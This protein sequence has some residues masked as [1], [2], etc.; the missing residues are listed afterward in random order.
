MRKVMMAAAAATTVLLASGLVGARA[1]DMSLPPLY[2]SEPEP[3]VEFG[4]GWYLRGDLGYSSISAPMGSPPVE[5]ITSA[6]TTYAPSSA[7]SVSND[8]KARYGAINATLGAGYQF[9]RWFRMDATFDWHQNHTITAKTYGANCAKINSLDDIVYQNPVCNV[10]D[11]LHVETWTGLVNAYGDLGTWFGVTPYF[12]G[13]IGLTNIRATANENY[14]KNDGTAYGDL[15]VNSTTVHYGYPGGQANSQNLT[16]FSFALMAG[17]AYDLAPHLKLDLGYRYLNM[18]G[19]SVVDSS[20][21][22]TR[23]TLDAQEV[24]AGLRWTPDL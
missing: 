20:G 1:A 2:Q 6:D 9:N 13:G 7:S 22:V 14:Y 15:N 3:M 11:T 23:K 19:L 17:L 24:R 10:T 21:D 12:G 4:S 18:G 8:R 16:N 5:L